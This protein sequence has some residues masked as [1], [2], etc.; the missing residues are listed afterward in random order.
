LD[1]A[2]KIINTERD[3]PQI[4]D[5]MYVFFFIFEIK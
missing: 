1:R 2:M 4:R 3:S 5:R